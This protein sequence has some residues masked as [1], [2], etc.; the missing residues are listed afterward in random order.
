MK[1]TWLVAVALAG[2]LAACAGNEQSASFEKAK[3]GIASQ[4]KDPSSAQ[5]RGMKAR[6]TDKG[7]VVV[8]GEV[9]AKNGFGGYIGFTPFIWQEGSFGGTIGANG[10]GAYLVNDFIE[11][12]C[13]GTQQAYLA[14]VM[15]SDRY[16]NHYRY[17]LKKSLKAFNEK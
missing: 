1:N 11:A 16:S 17:L 15:S 4:L 10:D 8:C 13:S 5:F 2:L 14:K 6:R 9:N 12:L 3:A 7:A